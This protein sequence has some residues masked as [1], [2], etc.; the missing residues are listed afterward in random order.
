MTYKCPHCEEE[1]NY[2]CYR[3]TTYSKES[4]SYSDQSHDSDECE[5]YDSDNYE[6]FCPECDHEVD[7]PDFTEITEEPT[8]QTTPQ[9]PPKPTTEEEIERKTE[10]INP[11]FKYIGNPNWLI[12]D[13]KTEYIKCL[14]CDT[15]V[16]TEQGETIPECPK[17][18]T[19]LKHPKK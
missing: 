19:E 12:E 10:I 8:S 13:T 9:T 14:V 15:E 7:D 16:I 5:Q 3:C 11:G 2:Y 6:Y 1:I 17:C 4:G 18:F